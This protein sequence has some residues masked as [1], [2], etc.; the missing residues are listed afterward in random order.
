MKMSQYQQKAR[1]TAVYPKN[2]WK[3]LYYVAMGLA[4]EAGEVA[5]KIKKH[6]RDGVCDFDSIADE[7]GDVLWYVSQMASEL[8]Y[9]L[10]TIA[11]NNITKLYSR[12]E[13]GVVQG[14]GDK[15]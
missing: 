5:N 15:R 1:K 7:L 14:E 12:L 6:I 4:G 9:D 3:G 8:G 2:T 11:E 13:R 10:D